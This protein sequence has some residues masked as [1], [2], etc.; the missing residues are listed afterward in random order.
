M[1]DCLL[2]AVCRLRSA[3][4][5]LLRAVCCLRS[6]ICRLR[7]AVCRLPSL[8]LRVSLC[9]DPLIHQRSLRCAQRRS[10]IRKRQEPT[11]QQGEVERLG[12]QHLGIDRERKVERHQQRGQHRA[13]GRVWRFDG[14]QPACQK[15]DQRD[16]EQ[17]E[18]G[19]G[20]VDRRERVAEQPQMCRH[21]QRIERGARPQIAQ[22][23][24]EAAP[25]GQPVRR[26]KVLALVRDQTGARELAPE[27][28]A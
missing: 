20:D 13:S 23:P 27:Q 4:C 22:I 7:S 1:G 14:E 21:E 18:D 8:C 16:V 9:F 15:V 11:E 2:P 3:A 24:G 12:E 10:A 26:R 6:A 28:Q 17:A 19:L 25:V 5:R